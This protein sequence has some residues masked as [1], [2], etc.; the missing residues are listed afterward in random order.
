MLDD[1]AIW[2]GEFL[3]KM[4]GAAFGSDAIFVAGQYHQTQTN[5]NGYKN[6]FAGKYTTS[7]ERIWFSGYEYRSASWVS[8]R[9]AL[10]SAGLGAHLERRWHPALLRSWQRWS[11][12]QRSLGSHG[13]IHGHRNGC[14]QSQR[15]GWL[16]RGIAGGTLQAR[17]IAKRV[18][19][20]LE[21]SSLTP[22]A[23]QRRARAAPG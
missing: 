19:V 4:V 21:E 3:P 18:G 20:K 2:E 17:A 15:G 22:H 8:G 10:W 14:F 16:A 13:A 7:G 12:D 6:N 9:R 11:R 5:K 23:R 1:G